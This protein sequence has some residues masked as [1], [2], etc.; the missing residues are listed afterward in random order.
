MSRRFYKRST[1][2]G[3]Q[4]DNFIVVEK[5]PR[6]KSKRRGRQKQPATDTSHTKSPNDPTTNPADTPGHS[7]LKL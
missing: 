1:P 6:K 4:L 3:L 2:N 5:K 7:C